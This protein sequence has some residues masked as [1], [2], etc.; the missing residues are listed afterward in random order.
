MLFS[1]LFPVVVFALGFANVAE[2]HFI[3]AVPT[4]IGFDDDLEGTSPC[5][6]FDPSVRKTVTEFPI[7]GSNVGV[8]TSH[9]EATW[10]FLAALTT[11]LTQWRSL[12][13]ALNQ[14][15]IGYFC[16]PQV[17]S[18]HEL[19][20]DEALLTYRLKQI[21]GPKDWAGKDAVLRVIQHTS[22][23]DLYQVM[24][25]LFLYLTVFKTATII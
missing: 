17:S 1:A 15:G 10:E 21:P 9:P 11:N 3:L 4:S 19:T 25:Y 16:E 20:F 13:P 23:G 18:I 8:S 12:T 14:T 5:G 2:S 22:H 6:N 7:T 24:T